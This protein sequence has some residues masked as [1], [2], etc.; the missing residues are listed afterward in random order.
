MC[1][2]IPQERIEIF[3]HSPLREKGGSM[4][5]IET[6][7]GVPIMITMETEVCLLHF[8]LI[9]TH[10]PMWSLVAF[11]TPFPCKLR[12]WKKKTSSMEDHSLLVSFSNT[13]RQGK[14]QQTRLTTKQ[15]LFWGSIVKTT[16]QGLTSLSHT[17]HPE[18][19]PS[20]HPYL[21]GSFCCYLFV[22]WDPSVMKTPTFSESEMRQLDKVGLAPLPCT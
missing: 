21:Q 18:H 13:R 9:L 16:H 19:W 14:L 12:N 1:S 2:W 10:E 8:R 11:P 15:N 4:Q 5:F 7:E 20:G 6:K 17:T 3:H 22:T